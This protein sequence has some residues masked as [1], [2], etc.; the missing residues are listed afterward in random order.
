MKNQ[1]KSKLFLWL[2]IFVG[3]TSTLIVILYQLTNKNKTSV[4]TIINKYIKIPCEEKQSE[5]E[6]VG[7]KLLK[8]KSKKDNLKTIKG[9]GPAIE[10]LLNENMIF[11]YSGLSS[12]SVADLQKMLEDKNLRL[13]N[14]E[15]W[16]SQAQEFL[17]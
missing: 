12:T 10:T 1:N 2:G 14:P 6:A 13:A 17:K 15:T 16:P 5:A 4:S 11:T 7:E 9:I 3:V 8:P